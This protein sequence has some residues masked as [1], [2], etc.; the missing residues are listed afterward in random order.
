MKNKMVVFLAVALVWVLSLTAAPSL[1]QEQKSQL[2]LIAEFHVKPAMIEEFET[3]VKREIELKYPH[4]FETYRTDDC[5]YYCLFPIEN[6]GGIDKLKKAELEWISKIGKEFDALLKS[7][8]GTIDYYKNGVVHLAPELS[9][10][11]AKPRYKPEEMKFVYWIFAYLELGKE[12]EFEALCKQYVD[13]YKSR[14][15]SMGWNTFVVEMGTEVPLYVI[16]MGGKSPAEFFTED[17]KQMKKLD[18]KKVEEMDK[19][20][21]SLLKKA[22]IKMGSPRLELSNIPKEK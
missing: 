3:V 11:P 18:R 1:A 6:Y 10:V 16:S 8:E 12:K 17:E 4:P 13:L 15:I 5:I 9:Y 21:N 2:Y 7:A 14:A 19:K 22:E 20:W